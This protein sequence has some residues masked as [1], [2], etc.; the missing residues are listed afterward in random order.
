MDQQ[1]RDHLQAHQAGVIKENPALKPLHDLLLSH[2][3][4]YTLLPVKEEDLDKLLT[5]GYIQSGWGARMSKGEGSRCHANSAFLW[6]AN[7]KHAAIVTGYGLSADGIWRQHTWV[8]NVDDCV[9]KRKKLFRIYETTV[10]RKLYFGYRM[11]DAEAIQFLDDNA[12]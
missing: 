2:G 5:R 10:K 7:R 12:F 11:T 6:D 9:H 8:V 1:Q 3:G 4:E